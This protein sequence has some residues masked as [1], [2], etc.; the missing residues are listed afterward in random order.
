MF[1]RTRLSVLSLRHLLVAVFLSVLILSGL[2]READAASVSSTIPNR[3]AIDAYVTAQMQ[4]LHI[5]GVALGIVHQN[6]VVYTQGYG[7]ADPAGRSMTAHTP[8]VL[9]SISKS[10]TALA[11]MQLVEQGKIT[12]D[13]PVQRYIP[14]FQVATPGASSQITIRN[15]LTHTSGLSPYLGGIRPASPNESVE[16][17][18]RA[19]RTTR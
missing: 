13:A 7:V 2:L 15:L 3:H 4:R 16:Q 8:F 11:I 1:W 14:W 12:L 17:F 18:V 6:Q 19:M 5:P 10:F 9:A